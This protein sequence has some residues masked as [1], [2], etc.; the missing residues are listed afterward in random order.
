[1]TFQLFL[2]FSFW[3]FLSADWEILCLVRLEEAR[4][5]AQCNTAQQLAELEK[6]SSRLS[7]DVS[8]SSS[9]SSKIGT[10]MF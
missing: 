9:E 4:E 10:H 7:K 2:F 5:I 8:E 3:S 1:M 6:I